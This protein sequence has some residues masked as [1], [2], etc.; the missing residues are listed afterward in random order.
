MTA[1]FFVLAGFLILIVVAVYSFACPTV[2]VFIIADRAWMAEKFQ[3][4]KTTTKWGQRRGLQRLV[5]NSAFY[6]S[7][8]SCEN[9]TVRGT[10][11]VL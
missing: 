1:I 10:L 11:V 5:A 6:L 8:K 4:A 3:E 7:F 9:S 2:L